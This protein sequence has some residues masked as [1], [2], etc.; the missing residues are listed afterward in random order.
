MSTI[1]EKN[2][3]IVSRFNYEVIQ[4]RSLPAFEDIMH[5]Q[6]VNHS[7]PHGAGNAGK[8]GVL[9]FLQHIWQVFPDLQVTINM[10]I[11]EGDLVMTY[12][13]FHGT[14]DGAFMGIEATGKSVSFSSIDIIR[15]KDEQAIEHWSIRDNNTL[16]QQL[17]QTR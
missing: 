16:W 14:H 3:A 5:A 6:F 1:L 2:K 17:T 15:L 9:Q 11:A 4:G 10:Q 13:T 12:K 8:E 7:V